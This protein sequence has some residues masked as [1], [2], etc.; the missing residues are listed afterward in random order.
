M[1]YDQRSL[2]WGW[3]DSLTEDSVE[4]IFNLLK[5]SEVDH[6]HELLQSYY[7]GY[8]PAYLR[9][10]SQSTEIALELEHG[11][12]VRVSE[13]TPLGVAV[14]AKSLPVVK[15]LCERYASREY[16]QEGRYVVKGYEFSNIL[17]PLIWKNRDID[18]LNYIL[19]Q[20]FFTL[21]P[22]DI[23]SIISLPDAKPWYQAHK[24]L[25]QSPAAHVTYQSLSNEAQVDLIRSL[26]DF[27]ISLPDVKIRK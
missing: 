18:T 5:D 25:L 27:I 11:N 2:K 14:I 10:E 23:L 15:Y 8:V 20:P 17:L 24:A 21:T 13:L 12:T 9:W 6:L 1:L 26:I 3:N 16:L 22:T 4:S 7:Q 19:R